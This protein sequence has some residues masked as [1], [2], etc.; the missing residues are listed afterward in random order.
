MSDTRVCAQNGR[1]ANVSQ[2][3]YLYS[4]HYAF[5]GSMD[6]YSKLTEQVTLICLM[7]QKKNPMTVIIQTKY[8]PSLDF[9]ECTW[10]T[11]FRFQQHIQWLAEKT[12]TWVT[13]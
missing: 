11:S 4:F 8:I 2:T 7:F 12:Y 1:D 9:Y 3:E 6:F 10:I 13:G 5:N